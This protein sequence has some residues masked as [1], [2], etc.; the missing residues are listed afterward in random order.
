MAN[1]NTAGFGLISAG[2][3]GSTPATQGQGKY[4]ID[5]AYDQD[6][7][8]GCSVRMK[9]GYIVEASST[10]T[11]ATIGVFNGIFYNAATTLKPTWANWYNQ[12]ITPANSEDITCFVIDNPFQLFVGSASAA[13][14]QANVGRTVS[15]TAAVPTGSEISGQCTNTLNIGGINDT[16]QQWRIIR[17]AEDPENNDITAAYCSFVFAQNLGQYLLN[18]ATAGNDWTI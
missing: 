16:T 4:Y 5:A 14:T 12:P 15:F 18:S 13:V 6:L 11:F 8:Q 17:S 7:F 3:V 9:N 2:T 1:S 10:A